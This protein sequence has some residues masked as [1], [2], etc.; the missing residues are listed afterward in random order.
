MKILY[1]DYNMFD[2][3]DIIDAFRF[4]GHDVVETD[5]PIRCNKDPKLIRERMYDFLDENS[6][7]IVFTSNFFTVISEVCQHYNTVYLSW[8]YDSPSVQLYEKEI[9]NPCN[10]IFSFDS[11]EC[12]RLRSKGI[13]NVFY[14]PLGTNVERLDNISIADSDVEKYASQLSMVA[15]LYDEAHNFYDRMYPNLNGYTKGYLSGLLNSQL[16]L[17]TANILEES[18][19]DS[20]ILADMIHALPYNISYGSL[21]DYK[22][23]YGEVVLARKVA[24][25]QRRMF[26]EE[27]SK[28]FQF[29]VYTPG[30]IEDIPNVIDMG[31]VNHLEDVHKVYRLSK[32]NLNITIPSI[33][34]GI[35]LRALNIMGAGG[36]LL[37]NYQSD[38]DDFFEQGIDYVCYSSLEEAKSLVDYY[39]NHDEERKEIAM[40][41]YR[42]VKECFTYRQMVEEIMTY[43]GG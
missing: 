23:I 33:K 32:I 40:N 19:N 10:Y 20:K 11:S 24:S 3:L 38:F 22:Y 1:V 28:Y 36:F 41:G 30:Y 13:N 8:T 31:V 16:N 5:I 27:L 7:D 6:F 17:V 29:K 37:T 26:I 34:S 18:L 39:L 4:L 15:S 42:K 9:M 21:I 43:F 35:P 25:L 12:R 2:K 14:M